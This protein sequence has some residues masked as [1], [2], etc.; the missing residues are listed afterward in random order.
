MTLMI[1]I[2]LRDTSLKRNNTV[3]VEQKQSIISLKSS[4]FHM[5][6]VICARFF[7]DRILPFSFPSVGKA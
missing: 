3:T 4:F 7:L 5:N 1:T 2:L 6:K